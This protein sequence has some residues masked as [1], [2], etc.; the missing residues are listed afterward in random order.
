[1]ADEDDDLNLD[2][3]D[4]ELD[5]ELGEG[6]DDQVDQPDEEADQPDEPQPLRTEDRQ[7][8]Q[9]DRQPSRR[10]RRIETL[11]SALAETRQRN[12]ELN[13]RIDQIF[14]GQNNRPSQGETPEQREQ[15]RALMTPEERLQETIRESNDTHR[16]EMAQLQFTLKDGSDR[17]AFEAKC[18]VDPFYAK[19]KPKVEEELASLQRQGM[20]ADREKVLYYLIGKN[21]VE[22]RGKQGKQQRQE[23]QRRVAANR[24][25]PANAGNDTGGG[26]SRPNSLERRL[27]NQLI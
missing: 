12:E 20:T 16:R 13:R 19:W 27:E 3:P 1:M 17:A 7:T 4:D 14:A 15:R 6:G 2:P 23:A 25:R 18:T 10:D 5:P 22:G 11:T 21:A 26:R 9:Q 24:T 8:G